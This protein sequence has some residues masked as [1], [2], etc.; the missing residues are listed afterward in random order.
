MA[1]VSRG[2]IDCCQVFVVQSPALRG[3]AVASDSV[4]FRQSPDRP[5]LQAGAFAGSSIE[6]AAVESPV[7]LKAERASGTKTSNG[8]QSQQ[9]TTRTGSS[10]ASPQRCHAA[11]SSW[12]VWNAGII[13]PAL[14]RLSALPAWQVELNRRRIRALASGWVI[15]TLLFGPACAHISASRRTSLYWGLLLICILSARGLN[16]RLAPSEREAPAATFFSRGVLD[17]VLFSSYFFN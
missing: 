6:L 4:Y 3:Q 13:L 9:T 2:Y 17:Q 10:G 7:V 15:L 11:G 12:P 14:S 16:E 5:D 1:R 8:S